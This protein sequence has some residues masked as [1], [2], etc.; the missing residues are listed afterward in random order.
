MDGWPGQGVFVSLSKPLMFF[1]CVDWDMLLGLL[2]VC[3][4]VV[5]RVLAWGF[6][7]NTEMVGACK[8][9]FFPWHLIRNENR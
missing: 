4:V 8:G 9:C 5:D 6:V 7:Y 2:F 1:C 3:C